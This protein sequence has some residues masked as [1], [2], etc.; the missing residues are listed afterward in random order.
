ML[1]TCANWRSCWIRRIS[2]THINL[3]SLLRDITQI[4][5]FRN[6]C[7]LLPTFLKGTGTEC[8][9]VN[10]RA[11][12]TGTEEVRLRG[13][14]K[15]TR[16]K[17]QALKKNIFVISY[18]PLRCKTPKTLGAAAQRNVGSE[19]L[20]PLKRWCPHFSLD[21]K[22]FLRCCFQDCSVLESPPFVHGG[23]SCLRHT[24]FAG[25]GE[26]HQDSRILVCTW[27]S[28]WVWVR[29]SPWIYA[30][31]TAYTVQVRHIIY[32]WHASCIYYTGGAA[33]V[34]ISSC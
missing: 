22:T 20:G 25:I 10:N 12:V 6:G 11:M 2:S 23:T 19:C 1:S 32:I 14:R 9:L 28:I 13:K 21:S 3:S 7:I 17:F 29:I 26:H 33:G 31:R 30:S 16:T 5:L 4:I 8:E 27:V 34:L 15:L 18:T 24:A